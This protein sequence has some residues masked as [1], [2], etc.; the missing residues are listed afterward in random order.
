MVVMRVAY[1]LVCLASACTPKGELHPDAT[2]DAMP[3]QCIEGLDPAQ[4]TTVENALS[5]IVG[6][7]YCGS[8]SGSGSGGAV[9]K[10]CTRPLGVVVGVKTRDGAYRVQAFG[11]DA[12]GVPMTTDRIFE[13]GSVMKN[14]RW[15]TLHRL[16]QLGQPGVVN[17]DADV[18]SFVAS[19]P[20]ASGTTIKTLMKHSSGMVDINDTGFVDDAKQHLTSTYSYAQMMEF[21]HKTNTATVTA[22]MVNGFSANHDY[23]YSSFGPLI[24]NEIIGQV[25]ESDPMDVVR[26][27]VFKPLGITSMSQVG[28][29]PEPPNVAHGYGD[30]SSSDAPNGFVDAPQNTVALSSGFGGLLYSNACDLLHY[31]HAE[32]T[33]TTFIHADTLARMMSDHNDVADGL[34]GEGVFDYQP[35]WGDFWGHLGAGIHAQSSAIAHRPSDDLSIVVLAN[36]NSEWDNFVT[37][38]FLVKQLGM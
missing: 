27:L 34:V 22:G 4:A 14:I 11:V 19:P 17:L 9:K 6:L 32:F 1:I 38:T 35:A 2:T 18:S 7:P 20:L 8:G 30:G 26:E 10:P 21:L 31:T 16:A 33:D 12:P 29:E 23:R 37:P 5:S 24:A 15:V 36:V 25:T 3:L 13:I 28:L